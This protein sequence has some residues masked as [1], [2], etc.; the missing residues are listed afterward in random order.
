MFY[1]QSCEKKNVSEELDL[2]FDFSKKNND[3]L[4]GTMKR[5]TNNVMEISKFSLQHAILLE[6]HY[7]VCIF[8][9]KYGTQ[10]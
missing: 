9:E 10:G 2:E 1:S 7:R 5:F 4:V 6:S 8:I 3:Q